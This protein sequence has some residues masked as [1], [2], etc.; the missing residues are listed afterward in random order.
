[1]KCLLRPLIFVLKCLCKQKGK[2][3]LGDA[4]SQL[5]PNSTKKSGRKELT[6]AKSLIKYN[7]L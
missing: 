4:I 7:S 5:H 2:I 3:I 1:M 6:K